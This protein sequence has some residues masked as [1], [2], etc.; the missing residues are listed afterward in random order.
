MTY[1]DLI[2]NIMNLNLFFFTLR[3]KKKFKSIFYLYDGFTNKSSLQHTQI[4]K[5]FSVLLSGSLRSLHDLNH[6]LFSR[7]GE[8]N[9]L[10]IHFSPYLDVRSSS[11]KSYPKSSG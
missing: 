10:L 2:T 9:S 5:L 4:W 3:A 8:K 6:Y 7:G 11:S 1:V